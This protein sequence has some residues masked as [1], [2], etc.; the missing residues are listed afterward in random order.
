MAILLL[1]YQPK[2]SQMIVD[3]AALI[4][5]YERVEQSCADIKADAGAELL[6][7]FS[8]EFDEGYASAISAKLENIIEERVD[9]KQARKR[10]YSV[11]VEA[12]QNIKHHSPKDSEG[13][14]N[15]GFT[16]YLKDEKICA[17]FVNLVNKHSSKKLTKRYMEVN[18]MSR[19]AL[20]KLYMDTMTNGELSERGGAGLGIITIVLRS[21]N[22]SE[23][24]LTHLSAELDIFESLV[25]VDVPELLNQA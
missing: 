3:S 18:K 19:E 2:L 1:Y 11:Y 6:M 23:V 8:G 20:K 5:F 4:R 13:L 10:F 22:P 16:I 7:N 14:V 17:R 21:Q 24:N 9:D 12:V 25:Q 15:A